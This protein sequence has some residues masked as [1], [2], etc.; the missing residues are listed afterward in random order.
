[1]ALVLLAG[2]SLVA[3]LAHAR[4]LRIAVA[5]AAISA[6]IT[7]I[8][9][10]DQLAQRWPAADEGARVIA[11]VRLDSLVRQG[12]SGLEF[13]AELSIEAPA[14]AARKL[15]ARVF[16][17]D[18]PRPV[19]RA[20]EEWRLLLRMGTPRFNTN[21][22]GFDEQREFFRE[23]LQA[24]AVVLPFTGNLRAKAAEDSLLT[25]R[26]RIAERIRAA[27]VDRD[28][29]ALFA[30]LAVGA[31]GAVSREQWQVFSATGTTHLVAISGMH[32]TLFCWIVVALMRRLWAVWPALAQRIER[33]VFAASL[34][35]LAAFGYALLAGFGIPTQRTVIML[36][37]WWLLKLSGRVHAPFAVLGLALIGVLV[38][39]PLGPLSS[40][41]WLSFVAMATLVASGELE[42]RGWRAWL[43]ENLRTQWRVGV[44]LVPFTIAWFQSVSIAGLLVNLLAIPVFSFV[45][46]PI[47]LAGSALD[48]VAEGVAAPLWWLGER[49]H[50]VLWPSLVAIAAHPL[51]AVELS[52]P[53]WQLLLLALLA[54]LVIT[55]GRRPIFG[56]ARI[57][58]A[59]TGAGLVG[60]LLIVAF[61]AARHETPRAGEV[62]VTVLDVGDAVALVI[63]TRRHALVLDTGEQYGDDG[64]GAERFVL[65]A[66]RDFAINKVDLLL[67]AQSHAQRAVG[68]ARLM[69]GV[70][71]SRVI[72][73]GEW[74]G[75]S[76]P[77]E[78]CASA[79]AWR[80]D[81]VDFETFGLAGGSCVLRLGFAQ[82]PTLLVPER[83]DAK[84]AEVL[85]A[86]EQSRLAAT[87]LLVPR[88]GSPTAFVA[89]FAAAVAP[90]WLLLPGRQVTSARM[91]EL[92]VAWSVDP[93]RIVA[94]T[95]RGAYT[96]HLRAGLPP[97]W[98]EHAALQGNPIWRY[99]P[100]LESSGR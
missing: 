28:A 59:A 97:R 67:L 27:V 19:P 56:S 25:L 14:N 64:R 50:D 58:A 91:A 1:M 66:L 12:G 7:L 23:R 21:P 46:V 87:L 42:G 11:L 45:L 40:G 48:A 96:L 100:R 5:I 24:R 82:G 3:P 63:R 83:V 74:P 43:R 29:A 32:V 18:P 26:A 76:R 77:I 86:R 8:V 55:V 89:A 88:R 60:M 72:A 71:V 38:I 39:D 36:G 99:H 57:A 93:T 6:L 13:D 20:G 69:A 41:F 54:M 85:A 90:Q 98:I 61:P 53:R 65:P 10:L 52:M 9:A 2:V 73:G 34:G 44:A 51:A 49:T 75:A 30:G 15:R 81:G 92:A 35:V 79:R 16:W 95:R 47:A 80:W 31:T 62:M 84:E 22:G 70:A 78:P 94:T 37:I 4:G 33:E 68:A 17:R